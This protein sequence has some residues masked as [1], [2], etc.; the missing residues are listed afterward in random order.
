MPLSACEIVVR[1]DSARPALPAAAG[2][3]RLG[4]AVAKRGRPRKLDAKRKPSGRLASVFDEG[5]P[6]VLQKRAAEVGE[7]PDYPLKAR[8]RFAGYVIGRLYLAQAF[9]K[10]EKI[11]E[12]RHNALERYASAHLALYGPGTAQ[13]VMRDL[14]GARG[15]ATPGDK[16]P[17]AK[18]YAKFKRWYAAVLILPPSPGCRLLTHQIVE[19]AVLYEMAPTS[20]AELHALVRA[21]DRLRDL[22]GVGLESTRGGRR[23]DLPKSTHNGRGRRDV[24]AVFNREVF[25][26]SDE[27]LAAALAKY[28]LLPPSGSAD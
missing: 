12:A 16:D 2:F 23:R 26:P 15:R 5:H 21:A 11:A 8:L 7:H 27:D 3:A 13:S 20:A 9:G 1:P 22:M 6:M 17:L 10:D 24:L 19:R 4:D 14:A 18:L 25:G 28:R